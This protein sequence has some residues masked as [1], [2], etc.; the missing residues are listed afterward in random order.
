MNVLKKLATAVFT[1]VVSLSASTDTRAT[2]IVPPGHVF[3]ARD[4][5]KD[6]VLSFEE[7]RD[8]RDVP[9]A[10]QEWVTLQEKIRFYQW[11]LDADDRT[12]RVEWTLQYSEIQRQTQRNLALLSLP[13]AMQDQIRKEEDK[14]RAEA[15][16]KAVAEY[17]EAS[18]RFD[19]DGDGRL[20]EK[21]QKAYAIHRL[22][23][24][25]EKVKQAREARDRRAAKNQ[26]L[27]ELPSFIG[28]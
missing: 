3:H 18:K 5:D 27:E 19:T 2:R 23:Q 20:N 1:V 21:E 6:G 15:A 8:R 22:E 16:T 13:E 4:K 28:K 17:H 7:F 25:K 26:S 14:K 11:D 24:L 10:N 9:A 12:S